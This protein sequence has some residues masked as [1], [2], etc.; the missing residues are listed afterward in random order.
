MWPPERV[1]I[2]PANDRERSAVRT[3]QRALRVDETGDMDDATKAALRGV[4]NLFKLPVTGVLDR[5]TAEA[6]DRL[7]PPSLR[8]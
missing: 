3:A 8:E 7:R 5:A 4:Q 2:A 1:I 6:L